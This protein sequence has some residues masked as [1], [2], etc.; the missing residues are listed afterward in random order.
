ML[1]FPFKTMEKQVPTEQEDFCDS[2]IRL[3]TK[4]VFSIYPSS[5]EL[6]TDGQGRCCCLVKQGWEK[7][8][9]KHLMLLKACSCGSDS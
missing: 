5:L 3:L 9:P 1:E 6:G 4:R 8:S 7:L 2:G